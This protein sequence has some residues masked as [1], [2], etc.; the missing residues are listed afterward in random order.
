[1]N[2]NY[3]NCFCVE[4]CSKTQEIRTNKIILQDPNNPNISFSLYVKDGNLI[5][6]K[7]TIVREEEEII[8]ETA[9]TQENGNNSNL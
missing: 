7:N 8:Y 6:S 3:N 1:M 9:S 5:K 2:N 4:G